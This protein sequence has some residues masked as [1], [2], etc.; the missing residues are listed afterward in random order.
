LRGEVIG[1][2]LVNVLAASRAVAG[3]EEIA[4]LL[5][6]DP[7]RLALPAQ[8]VQA[9]W[10]EALGSDG[11]GVDMG[12]RNTT[13]SLWRGGALRGVM[14]V[15]AGGWDA[16]CALG[17]AC[18]VTD[19]RAERLKTEYAAGKFDAVQREWIQD[20]LRPMLERWVD[21]VARGLA[22]LAGGETLPAAVWLWGGGA[23]LPDAAGALRGLSHGLGLSFDGFPMV[24]LLSPA[25]ATGVDNHS[26]VTLGGMG[27]NVL[28][29]ARAAAAPAA[30][31]QGLLTEATLAAAEAEGI[32][33]WVPVDD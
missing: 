19:A 27:V 9:A 6:L 17:R 1:L 28:A 25:E 13:L 31:L 8:G 33:T 29:L 10:R 3:A 30:P 14:S 24:R 12:G 22:E 15:P 16:T 23:E 32:S 18:R 11:I 21:A 2:R 26:G 5:K 20:V 4:D 7:P